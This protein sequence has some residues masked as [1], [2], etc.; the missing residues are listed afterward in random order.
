M[1]LCGIC[2]Q[3]QSKYKCPKCC[4]QYCSLICFKSETHR[5]KDR[6]IEEEQEQNQESKS[7]QGQVQATQENSSSTH[8]ED[9][10]TNNTTPNKFDRLISDPQIQAMLKIKSLQFHLSTILRILSDPSL[11][12]EQSTEGRREIANKK[13]CN[14]RIGGVEENEVIEDF[15]TRTLTLLQEVE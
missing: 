5:A 7:K 12:N 14:L 6:S 11:T 13:L 15:V 4:V 8:N 1:I 9:S 10:S 2:N 3:E